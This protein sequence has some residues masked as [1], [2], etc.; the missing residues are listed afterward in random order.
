MFDKEKFVQNLKENRAVY[1]TAISVLLVMIFIVAA[2]VATNR[3]KQTAPDVTTPTP[4]TTT[5]T[6]KKPTTVPDDPTSDVGS[7]LPSFSL[8]VSGKL[9]GVHDS[10]LQVFSPTM[11]DYRVH[12]G[13]D[14]LANENTPVCAVAD[15]TVMQI[16]EDVR[17]GQC[18]AVKHNGD[19]ISIYKNVSADFPTGIIEGAKVKAGQQIASV[20]STAMVE[21][22]DESHLHFEMTVGGLSVDPLE[23]FTAKDVE[24]LQKDTTYEQNTTDK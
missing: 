24:T 23:Y 19:A 10:E 9:S 16:W 3:N 6:T 12:L 7:K 15:G 5:T 14:I 2:V 21:I 17:M 11:N 8:P 4:T 20:G 1:L 22:A 13:I 18:I